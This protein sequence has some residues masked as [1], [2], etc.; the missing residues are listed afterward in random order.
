MLSEGEGTDWAGSE[1]RVFALN[2]AVH[3]RVHADTQ[4][5]GSPHG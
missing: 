5:P 3:L 2:C 4:D 1:G